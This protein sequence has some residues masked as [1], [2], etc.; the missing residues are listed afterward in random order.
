MI[1][2]NLAAQVPKITVIYLNFCD[3]LDEH[4][5]E[6]E[7][8]DKEEEVV[9][10]AMEVTMSAQRYNLTEHEE[11]Y[12]LEILSPLNTCIGVP[13]MTRVSSTKV[14]I[15]TMV[16]FFQLI[17]FSSFYCCIHA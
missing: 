12:L 4:K 11:K 10:D 7:D 17:F 3:I 5:E 8:D 15:N 9:E 6:E 13:F 2:F 16:C 1:H 14:N